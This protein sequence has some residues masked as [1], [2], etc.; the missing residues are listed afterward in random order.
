MRF[1]NDG[2]S[3]WGEIGLSVSRR[4]I[5]LTVFFLC[6]LVMRDSPVSATVTCDIP[7]PEDSMR[8]RCRNVPEYFVDNIR[9]KMRVIEARIE[10]RKS[11]RAEGRDEAHFDV[12]D[13][14]YQCPDAQGSCSTQWVYIPSP[15]G[16]SGL[17]GPNNFSGSSGFGQ[18]A[19]IQ[20][21][22]GAGIGD[23]AILALNP[24]DAID[25]SGAGA[26][27]GGEVC[28]YGDGRLVFVNT[29]VTPR[30]QS[31]PSTVKKGENTCGQISGPGQVIFLPSEDDNSASASNSQVGSSE[32]SFSVRSLSGC[33]VT[34]DEALNL[35]TAPG[36]SILGLVPS[37]STVTA[38][39]RTA[40]WFKVSHDNREGWV[41]SGY[42]TTSGDCD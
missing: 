11:A 32:Q 36:G 28:F 3:A 2:A 21:I 26:A 4:F 14:G 23:P 35:R 24:I 31:S 16:V 19:H 9:V 12:F 33:Q 42:V 8:F 6:I 7:D 10:E 15:G 30:T 40:Y 22:G 25:V 13:F 41:S 38:S 1:S 37:G 18:G 27:S 17:S 34:A 5:S 39:E 29:S 20:R